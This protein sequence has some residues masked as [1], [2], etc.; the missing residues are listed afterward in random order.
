MSMMSSSWASASITAIAT[1]EPLHEEKEVE[2]WMPNPDDRFVSSDYI[3]GCLENPRFRQEYGDSSLCEAGERERLERLSSQPLKMVNYTETGFT[4]VRVV[5]DEVFQE[6]LTYGNDKVVGHMEETWPLSSTY[7][8]HWESTTIMKNVE[9]CVEYVDHS[10]DLKERLNIMAQHMVEDWIGYEVLPCSMYGIRTYTEGAVIPPYVDQ[11]PFVLTAVLNVHQA[12]KEEWPLEILGHDGTE[13]NVSMKSGDMVLYE[14]HSVRHG[15]PYPFQGHHFA[16]VYFHFVPVSASNENNIV[17]PTSEQADLAKLYDS[18]YRNRHDRKKEYDTNRT[19][20]PPYIQGD[21][22][23]RRWKG[24]QIDEKPPK[25]KDRSHLED[26]SLESDLAVGSTLAHKY[27]NERQYNELEELLE[28]D[29]DKIHALDENGWLPLHEAARSGS[30]AI[31]KLLVE[32][33]SK[34]N[35]RS[36][37]GTGGTPLWLAENS[38]ERNHAVIKY[39]KSAGAVNIAPGKRTTHSSTRK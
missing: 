9:N 16:N 37:N 25:P 39:L 34:I 20:W 22:E 38:L 30:V 1:T 21:K 13:Y 12:I 10:D 23:Q 18:I 8:N 28:N 17:S 24:T 2:K 29:P 27:A 35:T 6:L 5:D 26:P 4:K 31:V 7:L 11:Y 15:R 3:K 33:G 32:K 14:G 36:N 19:T